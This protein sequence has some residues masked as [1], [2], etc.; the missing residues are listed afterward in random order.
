MAAASI[1]AC[2]QQPDQWFTGLVVTDGSGAPRLGP[3]ENYSDS[4]LRQVRKKEQKKAAVIGEYAA[5][6]LLDYPSESV[7]EGCIEE[8]I[9]DILLV[10]N[11]SHPEIVYTH[12][13]ADK[14]DTHVAVALRVIKAILAMSEPARPKNLYGCEGWRDLDWMLDEDKIPF[15]LNSHE[16]LQASLLGV[17][18]SQISGGKRYDLAALGRR[19]AHA[20]FFQPHEVDSAPGMTFAMDLTPTI[21]GRGGNIAEY[22][23]AYIQRFAQDV[24]DRFRRLS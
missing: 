7:K 13:L 6:I 2:F 20:T 24:E 12:N 18:D 3:Y 10:L 11:A 14:H 8:V 16:S 15:M 17:F 23:L 22:V 19:R 4:E 21:Q 5:L 9:Q 1:L